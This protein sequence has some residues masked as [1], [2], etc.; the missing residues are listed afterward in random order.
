MSETVPDFF[1][2]LDVIGDSRSYF[3]LMRSTGRAVREP[4]HDTLMVTGFDEVLEVLNDKSGTFSNA[5]S[6]VGPIP[7]L[8][9]A[10]RRGDIRD[11]LEAHRATMPW[12]DHLVCMDGKR[13]AEH[14]MLLGSLL[15]Y[16]RL[17]QNE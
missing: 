16:K 7:A 1:S 5:C 2:D 17:K 4:Y 12:A 15:T 8:P 9:F 14:R 11:Q 3:D 13:H 10:P 6:V